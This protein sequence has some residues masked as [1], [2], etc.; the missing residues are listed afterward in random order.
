M[1]EALDLVR[2]GMSGCHGKSSSAATKGGFH[3]ARVILL[4][5]LPGCR[6]L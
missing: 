3:L 2:V 4:R 6:M 5:R 1:V